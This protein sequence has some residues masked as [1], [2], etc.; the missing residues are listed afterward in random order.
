MSGSLGCFPGARLLRSR[1]DCAVCRSAVRTAEERCRGEASRTAATVVAV[2]VVAVVV[3]VV[4][5]T[6]G[7]EAGHPTFA[8]PEG[9][10]R[11][12]CRLL[13]HTPHPRSLLLDRKQIA[14]IGLEPKYIILINLLGSCPTF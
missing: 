11:S 2:V 3:V 7:H 14:Q 4:E 13:T 6:K 5:E 10:L 12:V 9:F 8:V 1:T